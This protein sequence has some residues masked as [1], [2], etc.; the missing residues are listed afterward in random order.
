MLKNLLL[1]HYNLLCIGY[2]LKFGLCSHD[3][4]KWENSWFLLDEKPISLRPGHW[5]NPE[6]SRL[7][8]Y[9]AVKRFLLST[10]HQNQCRH[11][12]SLIINSVMDDT[13]YIHDVRDTLIWNHPST[14]RLHAA[15]PH[16]APYGRVSFVHVLNQCAE[17]LLFY[18][19]LLSCLF[20][21]YFP[22]ISVVMCKF[23]CTR[24]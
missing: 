3:R 18:M 2:Q 19:S 9:I 15:T 16:H 14:T 23:I 21:S 6:R 5:S 11:Q 17:L 10:W 24:F 12:P 20:L 8:D 13:S 22:L 4:L 1:V 7:L